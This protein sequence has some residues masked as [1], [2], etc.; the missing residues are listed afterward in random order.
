MQSPENTK[1]DKKAFLIE[2]YKEIEEQNR[3]GKTRNLKKRREHFI[4]GW[5]Q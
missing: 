4:Q 2:Q 1:E 5:V 3:M